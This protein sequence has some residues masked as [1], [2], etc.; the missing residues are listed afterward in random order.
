MSQDY[1]L[2]EKSK[3]EDSNTEDSGSGIDTEESRKERYVKGK[4]SLYI[5]RF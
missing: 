2:S 5:L 4:Q 1:S 3:A